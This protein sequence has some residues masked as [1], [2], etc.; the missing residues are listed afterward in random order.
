MQRA[1]GVLVL[2]LCAAMLAVLPG[3]T[4]APTLALVGVSVDGSPMTSTVV[5]NGWGGQ[6]LTIAGTAPDTSGPLAV[7]IGSSTCAVPPT[8][9]GTGAFTIACVLPVLPVGAVNDVTVTLGGASATLQAAV[10]APANLTVESVAGC[11]DNGTTSTAGCPQ[12]G[13]L[14][15]QLRGSDFGPN[16][17]ALVGGKVCPT[18]ALPSASS[19]TCLLPAGSGT[20]PLTVVSDHG[21]VETGL[22][23]AYAGSEPP[24]AL[25]APTGVT[26]VAGDGQATVSWSTAADPAATAYRVTPSTPAGPLPAVSFTVPASGQAATMSGVVGGLANGTPVTFTVAAEEAGQT[27]DEST[28]TAP[29]V[30]AGLPGAPSAL[31]TRATFGGLRVSW[32]APAADGG[33]PVSGYTVTAFRNGVAAATAQATGTSTLLRLRTGVYVL[34]VSATN[35]V[36]TGPASA[37]TAPK[38]VIG[39]P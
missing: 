34:E 36:G 14:T 37:P 25:P 1:L 6:V 38:L 4:A 16:A 5:V 2:V 39:R 18:T 7:T 23:V 10:D 20:Q 11:V 21:V 19:W 8:L 12:A 30:P 22:T 29:V 24:P 32:T 26:A 28:A 33:S 27:G 17:V 15:L 3:A 35:A 13:G 31:A 9:T